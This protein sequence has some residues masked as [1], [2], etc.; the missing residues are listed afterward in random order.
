M[1]DCT[2]NF[3]VVRP[4]TSPSLGTC[5]EVYALA[6]V[7]SNHEVARTSQLDVACPCSATIKKIPFDVPEKIITTKK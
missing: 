1:F 7:L 2:F 5:L 4:L 6:G 3:Q